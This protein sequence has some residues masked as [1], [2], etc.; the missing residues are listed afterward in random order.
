M[1]F[2][3]DSLITEQQYS[4]GNNGSLRKRYFINL[5]VSVVY[6]KVTNLED[7]L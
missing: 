7:W 1:G 3:K 6:K 4:G 2:N 5:R